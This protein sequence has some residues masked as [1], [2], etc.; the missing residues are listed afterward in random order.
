MDHTKVGVSQKASQKVLC[1]LLQSQ[2]HA[3]MAVRI[4][5]ANFLGSFMDQMQEVALVFEE[6]SD[7]LELADLTEG[8]YPQLVLLGPLQQTSLPKL[9]PTVSWSFFQASFFPADVDGPTSAAICASCLVGDD[10]GSCPTSSSFFT[11]S[12]H[13][14]TLPTVGDQPSCRACALIFI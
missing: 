5:L 6:L 7:P 8:Y 2:D 10:P 13:L 9:H 12:L 11:S 3:H 1:S 4:I 14:S